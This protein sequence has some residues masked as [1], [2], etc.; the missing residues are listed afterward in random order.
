MI[1]ACTPS[2][3]MKKKR[4]SMGFENVPLLRGDWV[5]AEGW[6]GEIWRGFGRI[7]GGA[8]G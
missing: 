5:P 7:D 6:V 1:G 3:V 4:L 8:L 2:P